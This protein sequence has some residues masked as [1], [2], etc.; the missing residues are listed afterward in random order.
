[1]LKMPAIRI[2]LAVQNYQVIGQILILTQKFHPVIISVCWKFRFPDGQL[3]MPRL[4]ALMYQKVTK[5]LYRTGPVLLPFG[6]FLKKVR[7][8]GNI[9]IFYTSAEWIFFS[10]GNSRPTVPHVRDQ[11]PTINYRD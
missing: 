9:I 6:I 4:W 8:E 2:P 10:F 3:M 5:L 1:M 11:P 7:P